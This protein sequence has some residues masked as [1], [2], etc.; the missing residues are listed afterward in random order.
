[1]L[2]KGFWL[3]SP[4]LGRI[5][6]GFSLLEVLVA[7]VIVGVGL[8]ATLSVMKVVNQSR[9]ALAERTAYQQ[10]GDAIFENNRQVIKRHPQSAFPV[11]QPNNPTNVFGSLASTSCSGAGS[12][13]LQSD[14]QSTICNLTWPPGAGAHVVQVTYWVIC[15]SARSCDTPRSIRV[16]LTFQ[17]VGAPSSRIYERVAFFTK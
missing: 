4:R 16:N 9:E 5:E 11:P 6:G 15:D 3:N 2:R 1:M 8:V 14:V 13:S 17:P 7:T 12:G 10:L